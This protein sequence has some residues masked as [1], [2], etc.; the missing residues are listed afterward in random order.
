MNVPSYSGNAF[1]DIKRPRYLTVAWVLLLLLGLFFVFAPLSDLTADRSTGLPSDHTGTFH[2][3][4]G[5]SWSA[6]K[7][8]SRGITKYVTLL[9]T[10]YAVHELVFGI[11]FIT[12]L[13]IPFRRGER[14]AW[15]VCWAVML[16]AITY[17]L[18]FGRHGST[19]LTRSL[20][21]V[22]GLPILLLIQLPRFYGRTALNQP[23]EHA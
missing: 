1:S 2:A 17:S 5:V 18:T 19:I 23:G 3:V 7:S 12:I 14:W 22:I 20:I 13:V 11:M 21:A 6:A 10:G 8:S 4:A 15:W 16:A 9:E